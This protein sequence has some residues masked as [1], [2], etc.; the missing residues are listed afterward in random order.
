MQP[1]DCR[2]HWGRT[3]SADTVVRRTRLTMSGRYADRRR[4]VMTR[5]DGA[6]GAGKGGDGQ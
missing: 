2:E 5:G 6:G 1:S 3:V 4:N